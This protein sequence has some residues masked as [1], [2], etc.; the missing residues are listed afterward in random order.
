M[1]QQNPSSPQLAVEPGFFRGRRIADLQQAMANGR[2][3]AE[4]LVRHAGAAI[5]R[6]NP[7]LNAFVHVD[8]AAAL[9]VARERDAERAS[10]KVRGPLHGIPVA[11]KDNV[12]TADM[13]TTMGAAHFLGHRPQTDA[14]CVALLRAAGAIVVG[15]TLT[16]EFAYGPTGD[17]SVQGAARNPWRVSQITGGSSAGSAAAVASGMVPVA[18][19]T[20]T[21][22]SVRVPSA[23]CGLVGFKPT[24]GRISDAGIFPLAPTL[25]DPGVLA[26]CVEDAQVFMQA[27]SDGAMVPATDTLGANGLRMGW[28][29]NVP[30][31]ID[32]AT[33]TACARAA[34]QRLV[35]GAV[36]E[37]PEVTQHARALQSALGAIQRAEAYEVHAERVESAP[38]KFDP[39]VLERLRAS[40]PVQGWEY[41]RAMKE[42]TRLQAEFARLFQQVDVLALPAVAITA[43]ALQQRSVAGPGSAGVRETLLG[44]TNPW[45]VLGLPAISLPAGWVDGM[46]V[47]LQLV[48]AAGADEKLLALAAS[49]WQPPQAR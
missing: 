23:L 11:I 46:P 21:G 27:L 14:R 15:K 32:D 10:G 12:D 49:R 4:D 2:L 6:L 30:F 9:V 25:E 13:P 38:E 8:I 16:H 41:V 42:R 33:V 34:A 44:L 24:H 40:R 3:T 36:Q 37:A 48:A 39:E 7:Q 31:A 29:A 20:D 1:T 35:G 47:G 18:L 26:N 22:G 5:E 43:P 45:N 17:R 28:V 19:G